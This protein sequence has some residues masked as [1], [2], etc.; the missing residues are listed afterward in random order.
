MI[1]LGIIRGGAGDSEAHNLSR[2]TGAFLMAHVSDKY[3]VTDIVIDAAGK[4]FVRGREVTPQEAIVHVD[5]VINALHN[6]SPEVFNIIST[7]NVPMTGS[8]ALAASIARHPLQSKDILAQHGI[9][10]PRRKIVNR[11]AR[12]LSVTGEP[13]S[14][15][16]YMASIETIAHDIFKTFLMPIQLRAAFKTAT[17]NQSTLRSSIARDYQTIITTLISLFSYTE[18]ILVEEYIEG[19][20]TKAGV[21]EGFRGQTMYPLMQPDAVNFT[22]EEKAVINN[23]AA[24]VHK[25]LDLSDY[26]HIDMVLHPKRGP[27]VLD[28]ES[29]PAFSED[30]F[31]PQSLELSGAKVG[32][33]ID[34]IVALALKQK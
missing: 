18:S 32:D 6:V 13:I 3:R 27:F 34:H 14:G 2:Q 26:S 19:K 7:F 20:K 4:W 5:V 10:M 23:I 9:A 22:H 30:S 11:P 31:L 28:T 25:A 8:K 1:R 24:R 16:D 17:S 21:I 12:E 33:F 29:N 15:S